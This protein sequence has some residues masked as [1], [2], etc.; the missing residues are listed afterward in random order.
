[1]VAHRS[2]SMSNMAPSLLPVQEKYT[3]YIYNHVWI[4][5]YICMLSSI[6][7]RVSIVSSHQSF[8]NFVTVVSLYNSLH[9]QYWI[10]T[11]FKTRTP[12]HNITHPN[13]VLNPDNISK[14]LQ[15]NIKKEIIC[16]IDNWKLI[17]YPDPASWP[18]VHQ[19]RPGIH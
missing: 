10:T 12:L 18:G 3:L 2:I 6:Y 8:L 4:Y 19:W 16:L 17:W 14:G 7:N 5:V 1:M 11:T 9:Q 15:I 13:T